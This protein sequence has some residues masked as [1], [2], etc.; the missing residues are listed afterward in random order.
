MNYDEIYYVNEVLMDMSAGSRYRILWMSEDGGECWWITL[1][2]QKRIPERVSVS[3]LTEWKRSGRIVRAEDPVHMQT[4]LNQ[5]QRERRDKRFEV[6][7]DAVSR[8]PGIYRPGERPAILAETADKTGIK[9]QN[10]YLYLGKYWKGGKT[11]DAL[12]DAGGKR[13]KC[14][15]YTKGEYKPLGRKKR[16][17]APSVEQCRRQPP[18]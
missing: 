15:D 3:E 12:A 11:P 5:K 18:D 9:L 8:E 4:V 14:R 6:I 16:E 7:A 1:D 17:G 10:L 13:G 2:Q